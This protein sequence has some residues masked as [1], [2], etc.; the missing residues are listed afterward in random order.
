M[1]CGLARRVESG[2]ESV[3]RLFASTT[4]SLMQIIDAFHL[5]ARKMSV[6]LSQRRCAALCDLIHIQALNTHFN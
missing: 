6:S 4:G 5:V 2:G 1:A 3:P